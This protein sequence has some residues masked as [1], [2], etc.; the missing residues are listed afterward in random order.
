MT[1]SKPMKLILSYKTIIKHL[2]ED[3]LF[4]R[5][6]RRN[7][8]YKKIKIWVAR[9]LVLSLAVGTISLA[10]GTAT[11]AQESVGVVSLTRQELNKYEGVDLTST[12]FDESRMNNK[13]KE[14]YNLLLDKEYEKQRDVLEEKGISKAEFMGEV[15][16]YLSEGTM[17]VRATRLIS[18]DALGS[19]LNVVITTALIATGAGS[20]G[21]LVKNLGKEGAKKWAKKYLSSKIVAVLANIG[22]KKLGTWVG[23]AVV[24][25]VDTYLDPGTFI[26]RQLDSVDSVPNS[27]YIEIW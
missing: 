11:Y 27:G 19:V 15:K 6:N 16:S 18:V 9:I 20:I 10:G 4:N 24:A 17:S 8:M 23:A 3:E 12:Q 22:A 5:I 1:F 7:I 25:I 21:E 13:E 26:A 2:T 14:L